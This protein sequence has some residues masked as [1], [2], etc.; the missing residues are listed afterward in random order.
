MVKVVV[1]AMVMV[2]VLVLVLVLVVCGSGISVAH[3]VAPYDHT[4]ILS[5]SWVRARRRSFLTFIPG[6]LEAI[7][8]S[9]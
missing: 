9:E 4:I 6:K 1:M 2:M 3:L 5:R 7:F 8:V